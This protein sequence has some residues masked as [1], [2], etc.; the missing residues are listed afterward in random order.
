MMGRRFR[1]ASLAAGCILAV[2]ACGS[3]APAGSSSA[4][5]SETSGNL[6]VLAAASLTESFTQIGDQFEAEHPGSKVTFSFGSSAALATQVNQ[7]A[8]A[9]VFAS[10][11]N[12]T[13][14]TVADHELAGPPVPFASNTLQI[15]VP[16]GNPGKIT[17]LD[18]FA[19]ESK[20]IALCAEQVPCG[21]AAK[22]VFE[23]AGITPKPDTLESDVKATVQKVEL[24][25]VDAALVYRTDV[26]AA[27][28]QVQGIEFAEAAKVVN[29]YPIA[30]LKS[31]RSPE[32]AKSFVDY[33]L[34][35]EG[36]AVL[37]KAG[38]GSP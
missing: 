33:V 11:S 35:P 20:T 29:T 25:E 3:P 31:S 22:Q 36:Q 8:P 30:T 26:N 9:D 17:G 16:K 38:F 1:A 5:V 28:G 13:M 34:S 27:G 6:T 19:D 32:L 23:L 7:G 24:G 10:A 12:A 37:S 2:A 18:D 14:Q 4:P 21:A 15:A